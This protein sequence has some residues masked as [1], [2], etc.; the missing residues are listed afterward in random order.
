MDDVTLEAPADLVAPPWAIRG[1]LVTGFPDLGLGVSFTFVSFELLS[2]E[3]GASTILFQS[4]AYGRVGARLPLEAGPRHAWTL[5]PALGYRG[6][7][8]RFFD[9]SRMG[10]PTATVGLDWFWGKPDRAAFDLQ[11][12]VG[13][14]AIL[15][16]PT[17]NHASVIWPDCRLSY[18]VA[19]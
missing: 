9:L 10:G 11:L 4:T 5:T 6:Q 18:G 16:D 8:T 19:F 12:S 15:V 17:D 3:V 2:L 1:S 7:E 14:L 13:V